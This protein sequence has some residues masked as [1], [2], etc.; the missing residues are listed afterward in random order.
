[1]LMWFRWTLPR[2][3]MDQLMRL[4][5]KVLLPI[6]FANLIVAATVILSGMYFFPTAT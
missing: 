5:W 4:E 1:M 2:L 3:R 6:G